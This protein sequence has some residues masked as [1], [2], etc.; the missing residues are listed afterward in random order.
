MSPKSN[1]LHLFILL[2]FSL[3]HHP[4]LVTVDPFTVSVVLHFPEHHI[5]GIKQYIAFSEWLS[6]LGNMHVRFIRGFVCVCGLL[7]H[8]FFNLFG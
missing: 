7:A 5:V 4:P 3:L 8:F 1:E 2:F 6:S